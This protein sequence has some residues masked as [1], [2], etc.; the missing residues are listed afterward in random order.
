MIAS[1]YP[2]CYRTYCFLHQFHQKE[3]IQATIGIANCCLGFQGM[4][5]LF[6]EYRCYCKESICS[7]HPR[8]WKIHSAKLMHIMGNLSLVAAAITSQPVL[9]FW[10]NSSHT[11]LNTYSFSLLGLE[12]QLTIESVVRCIHIASIVLGAPSTIKTVFDACLWIK[13]KYQKLNTICHLSFK[14][15]ISKIDLAI[16]FNTSVRG[17]ASAYHFLSD[18]NTNG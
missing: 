12:T 2:N 13:R 9:E 18:T 17:T 16:S 1:L 5:H 10:K 6:H 7:F 3:S 11:L 8:N 15:T 14:Q 4:H